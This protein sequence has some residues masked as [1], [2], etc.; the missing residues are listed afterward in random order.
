[1]D[2][3]DLLLSQSNDRDNEFD[4]VS[5]TGVQQTTKS[6]SDVESQFL[7]RERQHCRKWNNGQEIDN[8]DHDSVHALHFVQSDTD[9]NEDQHKVDPRC[10]HSLE[11]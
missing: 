11:L 7:C 3:H 1:L 2:N 6:L 4:G 8:E 9:R 5:E 10:E